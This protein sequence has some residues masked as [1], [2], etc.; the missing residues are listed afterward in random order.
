MV[1][2]HPQWQMF[3]WASSMWSSELC[4][5][6]SCEMYLDCDGHELIF[7]SHVEQAERSSQEVPFPVDHVCSH[8]MQALVVNQEDVA[9]LFRL[10]HEWVRKTSTPYQRIH[11]TYSGRNQKS[12]NRTMSDNSQTFDRPEIPLQGFFQKGKPSPCLLWRGSSLEAWSS[13]GS[14]W[15]WGHSEAGTQKTCPPSSSFRHILEKK[16]NDHV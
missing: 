15:G 14:S 2:E 6:L 13:D 5:F 16:Q 12:N 10:G 9:F 1:Q 3:C 11:T 4:I 8:S 7:W